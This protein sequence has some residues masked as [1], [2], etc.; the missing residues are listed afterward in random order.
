MTEIECA[1]NGG[2][3][4]YLAVMSTGLI[5]SSFFGQLI[6][7]HSHSSYCERIFQKKTFL[8]FF[9]S[10]LLYKIEMEPHLSNFVLWLCQLLHSR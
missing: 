9:N 6:S 1:P 3:Y 7:P 4:E 5:W 2:K 10:Q 8:H